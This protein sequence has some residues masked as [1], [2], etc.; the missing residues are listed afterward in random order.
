MI[1]SGQIVDLLTRR[2]YPGEIRVENGRIASLREVPSAPETY[3]LP[4]FVD[5]HIHIESSMLVPAAFAR[6]AVV[7]GTVATVS[8]PH[9]I[10]NV[11][12]IEGVRYM[13]KSGRQVPFKFFFGAPSCVPATGFEQAGAHL[14]PEEIDRLLQDPEILY[15]AEMMNY[16]GVIHGD[17][18]VMAK[19][20][21]ARQYGKPIDGHAP[22]LRGEA[23]QTYIEAGISTDHESFT[24][25]EGKEKL[26]KGMKLLIREGSAARNFEA[27]IDLLPAYPDRVMFC[28]D[29][30]HPDDLLLGHING[31][32]RRAI[33]R[34]IDP[35]IVLKAAC[36]HPVTHYGLPVGQL[37]P[38]DPADF[39][40]LRDLADLEVLETW[41]E[42]RCVARAG[43]P[44]IEVP[45][46]RIINQFAASP[47][48]AADFAL[49][50]TGR[51][52]RAIVAR[53]GELVTGSEVLSARI[54][55]GL[56]LADPARDLLKIAV[57]N[58]YADVAPAVAF[59]R[60]V[61][62]KA[63]AIASSVAHDSHNIVAVG[64][65]DASLCRAVNLVIGA[66]GGIAVT[67]PEGE[68]VLPLPVGGIMS[69]Q[70]GE[71]VA[72]GYQRLD[73]M[74]KALGSPLGAPF[75]T[76]SFMALLVIP[77]L[78]L[79]DQGLFDGDNFQFA[80]LFSD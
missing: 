52:V 59:I 18:E 72:A 70:A 61:G 3:L 13:Q 66:R 25:E 41:I 36:V 67:G 63:G 68:D 17:P 2:I 32:A 55:H 15:L 34:G 23:L 33:A 6:L 56:A 30:K 31:L 58:R 54:E 44:L 43:E 53:D 79:S 8:D 21:L 77:S 38:G 35:M 65:D 29:D 10:A 74:A 40:R 73:R 47:K 62:L 11:M 80:D 71:V 46:A 1:H 39:I 24:Y 22:G 45:P 20:A 16:P 69:D 64:C 50:A 27:L 37:R 78:K 12:G 9:E 42:G 28:S 57:V 19:L 26:E 7:H 48:Q 4:G 5:A 49:P 60:Q 75:M 76:L 14:G 51:Q